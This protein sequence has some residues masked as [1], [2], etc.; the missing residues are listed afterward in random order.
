MNNSKRHR[1][2]VHVVY[3]GA[4]R[5]SA[6][7]PEK[8]GRIAIGSLEAYAHDFVEF[9]RV[10]ALDG[11]DQLPH[12]PGAVAEL[13][14][15]AQQAPED[16]KRDN[17]SAWYAWSVHRKTLEKLQIEPVEDFRIDFEDGYGF[18]SDE[19]E[20]GHA[21][22]ASNEL[23]SAFAKGSM[24]AFSGFRVKSFGRETYDRAVRTLDIFLENLLKQ[25]ENRLPPNF[26]VTLPKVIGPDQ[27][28]DLCSR[29][30]DVEKEYGLPASSIGVELMIE[31]PESIIGHD[32]RIGVRGLV[33]AAEGR[34]TSVH[35][36]A[37]DYTGALGVSA[38]FQDIR[39]PACDFARHVIQAA[40]AGSSVR[41]VDSVT[42]EMP[43]PIHKGDILTE[44]QLAENKAAM[45]GGWLQHFRNATAS[46][47]AG[48][49]QSWDLH[50]NQ[51]V[52]RYAA[53]YAFFL[54]EFDS[55]AARLRRYI[56]KSTQAT[57][58]G[59]TFDDAA[60]VAG[61]VNFFE[62]GIGCGAFSEEEVV[63]ASGASMDDLSRQ[64]RP[65]SGSK[66]P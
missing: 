45:Y 25:T 34:C 46:M 7:T 51:L 38:S 40:L 19:E 48:F 55:Q 47:A 35:F 54:R 50:P 21:E 11:S 22:S 64:F 43:V 32:G 27:V 12:W 53:V 33:D 52:A 31:T 39:H 56:E 3:G 59:N 62:R 24:T 60:S 28:T 15:H 63:T 44:H 49:Y 23:G 2:P 10:F 29:L 26:V 20:D 13:A 58:T 42:T 4:D 14:S 9:A 1:S 36:G 57:L 41:L 5:F 37:Y 65:N 16:L 6:N 30:S 8:L 18:R 61:L 17:F 66:G